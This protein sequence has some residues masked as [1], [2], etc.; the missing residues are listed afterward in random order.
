MRIT[1]GSPED[2]STFMYGQ[3]TAQTMEMLQN[4]YQAFINTMQMHGGQVGQ[5]MIQQATREWELTNSIVA[6]NRAKAVLDAAGDA[7]QRNEV[8]YCRTLED[9]QVANP[10]MQRYLMANPTMRTALQEQTIDGYSGSYYDMEPGK[11]GMD[12]YDYRRVINGMVVDLPLEE[13]QDFPTSK[14]TI[15]S[16]ELLPDDRELLFYEKCASL[17][18]WDLQNMYMEM[19]EEDPSNK[20]GG[21][22]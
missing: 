20:F 16:E 10:V 22:R 4:D 6:Q 5:Y 21:K 14:F 19:T 8:Y 2:F 15:I 11:S 17:D 12:H 18:A 9:L 13:G 3:K 7:R 1:S